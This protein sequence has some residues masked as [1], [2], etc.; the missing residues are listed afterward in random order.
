M[1][2]TRTL[3]VALV[4]SIGIAGAGAFTA[5]ASPAGPTLTDSPTAGAT[6][7][8]DDAKQGLAFTREEE[9]MSRDLYQHFSDKYD[10]ARPFSNITGAEARHFASVGVLLDRYDLT[11]PAAGK[12]A[13]TY[14][15]P[16]LQKLY[17]QWKAQGDSSLAAAYEV[18]VDLERRDIA[19]LTDM[20]NASLPSDVSAVYARLLNGSENHLAAFTA[21]TQGTS[22]SQCDGQGP[23]RD[24]TGQGNGAGQGAN[25]RMGT[26]QRQGPQSRA[27]QGNAPAGGA[28]QGDCEG[29]G[30]NR[31]G[32][33]TASTSSGNGYGRTGERAADCALAASS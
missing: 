29:T 15:D 26:G 33:A 1:N 27:S 17:D 14:A 5:T 22:P 19:D 30:P 21:A 12:A 28:Q 4:A 18:G 25:A 32:D 2:R 20:A 23:A 9:R 31:T 7:L 6:T 16:E 24:G 11:D 3:G 13:G 8:S 10:E